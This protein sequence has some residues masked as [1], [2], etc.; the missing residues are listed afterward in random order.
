MKCLSNKDV[1]ACTDLPCLRA[2]RDLPVQICLEKT[3]RSGQG[4]PVTPCHCMRKGRRHCAMAQPRTAPLIGQLWSEGWGNFAM[5]ET[6]ASMWS[7]CRKMQ[8]CRDGWG[9]LPWSKFCSTASHLGFP[10]TWLCNHT[11]K[12]RNAAALADKNCRGGGGRLGR[13]SDFAALQNCFWWCKLL[14]PSPQ[15]WPAMQLTEQVVGGRGIVGRLL[16]DSSSRGSFSHSD[17]GPEGAMQPGSDIRSELGKR[18]THPYGVW[19]NREVWL[20]MTWPFMD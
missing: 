12:N 2:E 6:I 7:F 13:G 11:V 20:Q 8:L 18:S 1:Q 15:A 10:F 3:R 14:P 9:T 19:D 5:E 17:M 16:T 4:W